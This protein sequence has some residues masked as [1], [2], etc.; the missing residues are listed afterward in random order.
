MHVR[1]CVSPLCGHVHLLVVADGGR[2]R[3]LVVACHHTRADESI[4]SGTESET[5]N[6]ELHF[7]DCDV[8]T[9]CS[10]EQS[11][12]LYRY[13]FI[14]LRIA[15]ITREYADAGRIR[16]TFACMRDR[17]QR[18]TDL[19]WPL[20]SGGRTSELR[21]P[22]LWQRAAPPSAGARDKQCHARSAVAVA[23]RRVSCPG[24]VRTQQMSLM[25]CQ[26][27][28]VTFCRLALWPSC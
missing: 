11:H 21:Y 5:S 15:A 2:V 19:E 23:I 6:E 13:F 24:K 18:R 26:S 9:S 28:A 22:C 4:W 8:C 12:V 10:K 14:A 20:S 25:L 17:R 3:L 16:A 7:S 1:V 27:V